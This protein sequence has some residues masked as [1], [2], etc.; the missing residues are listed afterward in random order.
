MTCPGCSLR[1]PAGGPSGDRAW[2]G[3]PRVAG[4][5]P[6]HGAGMSVSL[7]SAS[8]GAGSPRRPPCAGTEAAGAR[9]EPPRAARHVAPAPGT[10]AGA[11]ETEPALGGHEG[12]AT[13]SSCDGGDNRHTERRCLCRTRPGG[14]GVEPPSTVQRPKPHHLGG[15]DGHRFQLPGSRAAHEER[16]SL[17]RARQGRH[18][19]RGRFISKQVR[20]G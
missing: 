3:S 2:G 12:R 1:P 17:A 16:G 14:S 20:G 8:E 5:L 6:S 4:Q 13:C 11:T 9:T 18:G 10:R 7:I 19:S 15:R